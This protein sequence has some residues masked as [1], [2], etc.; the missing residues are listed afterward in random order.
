[1]RFSWID[2][3]TVACL[4]VGAFASFGHAQRPAPVLKHTPS[5]PAKV[6]VASPAETELKR[7]LSA[8]ENA[9]N[10]G[11]PSN[12]A[13]ANQSLIALALR[14]MAHLRLIEGAFTPAADLY[15]RSLDFEDTADTHVDLAVTFLRAKKPDDSLTEASKAI[16]AD[17]ENPRGWHIQ[18]K[19][20]MMKRDWA[21]A[22]DSLSR[23][24]ALR[25]EPETAYALAIS[26][27]NSHQKD[28]AAAVF[29]DMRQRAPGNVGV[30]HVLFA[31][32]YRDAEYPDDAVREL[33]LALQADP[34]TPHAHYF[35]GLIALIKEGWVATPEIRTEFCAEL[36][37]YPRDFLSNYLMGAI[38]STARNYEQSDRYLRIA[39]QVDPSWPEPWL[40]LGLNAVGR[41]DSKTAEQMLRKAIALNGNRDSRSN[42]LIRKAYFALGRILNDSERKEEGRPLLQKARE[43]QER[44]QA[45]SRAGSNRSDMGGADAYLPAESSKADDVTSADFADRDSTSRLDAAVLARANLTEQET[46]QALQEEKQLRTLLGA[47]FN[48]LATSE[49]I[50]KKYDLALVHYQEAERWDPTVPGLTRNLG[51]AAARAEKFPEAIR[52]LSQVI[53]TT[54]QDKVARATLGMSY[55]MTDQHKK[56]VETIAPLGADVMADPGLAY[57]LADS[58][59]KQGAF[60]EAGDILA[61][62]ETQNL[63]PE[64][65][66]L[67][68]RTWDEVGNPRHAAEVMHRILKN[69]PSYPKA[70]YYAGLSYVHADRPADAAPEFE[71]ELRLNPNDADAKYNLGF[72]YLQQSKQDEAVALFKEVVAS[73]PTHAQANYQLGKVLLDKGDVASAVPYLETAARLIPNTDYVHYQLQIAYRKQSRLEDADRE[74]AIYKELKAQK[75]QQMV[76]QPSSNP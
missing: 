48:D 75:R 73:D 15:G 37:V 17:P 33:K 51:I 52:A 2:A 76:P 28:K 56:A 54:P 60:K 49:A 16:F 55:Y 35:L 11:D 4:V 29:A 3:L 31:R 10:S 5:A 47:S 68:G 57:A 41:G 14:Q 27:L 50:S 67:V 44:V 71:E 46:R 62:L 38:E 26:L 70:H 22:G 19:A 42:Y 53:G 34:K 58:Y 12:I 65:L 18:G 39:T 40:Y 25:W 59:A 8:V 69:D 61:Q 43:L 72:T 63:P 36:A 20:W 9:R 6:S 24:L 30:L 64:V 32:A 21:K 1:M 13:K 45:E 66:M 23:S 74:L 7:R